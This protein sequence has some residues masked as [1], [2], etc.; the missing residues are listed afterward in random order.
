MV[1]TLR[2]LVVCWYLL[3]VLRIH[4]EILSRRNSEKVSEIFF[5]VVYPP[6][7]YLIKFFVAKVLMSQSYLQ[8]ARIRKVFS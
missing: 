7:I 8:K 5:A 4:E 6:K 3:D 2:I 1:L